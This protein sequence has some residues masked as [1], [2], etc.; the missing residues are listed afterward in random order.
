M[1]CTSKANFNT[2]HNTKKYDSFH[3]EFMKRLMSKN[4]GDETHWYFFIDTGKNVMSLNIRALN[5]G[6]EIY[7]L[8]GCWQEEGSSY[9]DVCGTVN[10]TIYDLANDNIIADTKLCDKYGDC[11]EP[12]FSQCI[13]DMFLKTPSVSF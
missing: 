13:N 7:E 3:E 2:A 5:K 10:P 6:N 12:R 4:P 8:H 11:C 1:T 9:H